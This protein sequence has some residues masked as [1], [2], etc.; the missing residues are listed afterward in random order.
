MADPK[1]QRKP[2]RTLA[3]ST[4]GDQRKADEKATK[5]FTAFLADRSAEW[6]WVDE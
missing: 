3:T 1:K 5:A 2:G 4:A 6:H